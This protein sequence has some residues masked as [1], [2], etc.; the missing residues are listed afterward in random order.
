MIAVPAAAAGLTHVTV[1]SACLGPGAVTITDARERLI[2][3]VA[4]CSPYAVY[5]AGPIR[6]SAADSA[7]TLQIGSTTSWR[8]AVFA[9]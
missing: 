2:I 9:S 4:G 5:G 6:R 3:G 7:L 1:R 8:L